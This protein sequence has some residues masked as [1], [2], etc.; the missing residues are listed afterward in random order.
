MSALE[1]IADRVEIE[2]LRGEFAER[3]CEL[4]YLDTTRI[5]RPPYINRLST[6]CPR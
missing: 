3:V 2:A 5:P 1:V 6:S 4:R